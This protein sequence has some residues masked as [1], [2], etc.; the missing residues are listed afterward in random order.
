MEDRLGLARREEIVAQ[1]A[2]RSI[3]VVGDLMVD[4][5]LHGTAR[6]ISPEGPVMVVEIEDDTFKP[7]GA[8][9]VANNLRALGARVAIAGVVG[10]DDMGRLLRAEL[11]TWNTDVSGIV[12]DPSRPTT[13]KTRIVAQNQQVLRV[14]REQTHPINSEI[15]QRL[16][17]HIEDLLPGMDAIL[18]SD[19]RKGAITPDFARSLIEL[20]NVAG[21]PVMSNPKPVSA[22]WLPG[23]RALSLNQHEAAEL[24]GERL[25]EDD[26]LLKA[27]GRRLCNELNVEALLITRSVKG[28]SVW[29]RDGTYYAVPAHRVEVADGAGAGDTTIGVMTLALTCGASDLEAAELA[30]L[31]GACVVRKFGVATVSASELT[32]PPEL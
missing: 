20:A 1:F 9:N 28:L 21:I 6:R 17:A 12:T 8:A 26:A 22:R 29:K 23:V 3:L 14:D 16:L 4:E 7:G 5:Y 15:G 32:H 30:N 10:D 19:Y 31:A 2:Q 27:F 11:Q 18:I 25:P 24:G 13:R